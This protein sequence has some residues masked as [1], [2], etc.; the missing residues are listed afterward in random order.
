MVTNFCW[1][2]WDFFSLHTMI[3]VFRNYK[4]WTE[5]NEWSPVTMVPL[6][7]TTQIQHAPVHSSSN[8][9]HVSKKWFRKA[10]SRDKWGCQAVK[11][12]P[13]LFY[14][15][16]YSRKKSHLYIIKNFPKPEIRTLKVTEKETKRFK[17][18]LEWVEIQGRKSTK[19]WPAHPVRTRSQALRACF[20][21]QLT[22][23]PFL[24]HILNFH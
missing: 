23:A 8:V 17:Q 5:A 3:R 12:K 20:S 14:L 16:I 6:S 10:Q 19:S 4:S 1:F 21:L 11:Q 24:Y 22:A 9:P 7:L 13:T 2:A 18:F 15:A